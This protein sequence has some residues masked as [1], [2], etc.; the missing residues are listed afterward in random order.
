MIVCKDFM[1]HHRVVLDAG[2]K[3]LKIGKGEELSLKI[4]RKNK[5]ESRKV[6]L[7]EDILQKGNGNR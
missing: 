2:Q 7:A 5:V 4:N 6:V 1:E 3:S